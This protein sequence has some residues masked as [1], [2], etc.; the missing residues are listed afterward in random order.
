MRR[1]KSLF[2]PM[3]VFL[4][5]AVIAGLGFVTSGSGSKASAEVPQ[6]VQQESPYAP[7]TPPKPKPVPPTS[8]TIPV[9]PTTS[10]TA[11]APT[12]DGHR[13]GELVAQDVAAWGQTVANNDGTLTLKAI[14]RQPG[15]LPT[16]TRVNLELCAQHDTAVSDDGWDSPIQVIG[17]PD[18]GEINSY[19]QS[20]RH[21]YEDGMLL[22]PPSTIII[23]NSATHVAETSDGYPGEY[24]AA[25]QLVQVLSRGTCA[26]VQVEVQT[27]DLS[28]LVVGFAHTTIP[29]GEWRPDGGFT[30]LK[31][32]APGLTFKFEWDVN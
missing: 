26:P 24:D 25:G 29:F 13:A 17:L 12:G 14:G 20:P 19:W 15:D 10:T 9:P 11:P 21:T 30:R 27:T 6:S 32:G 7:P 23:D 1:I 16:T 31:I 8:T 18:D 22:S 3:I 5:I 4:V 2:N 28:T